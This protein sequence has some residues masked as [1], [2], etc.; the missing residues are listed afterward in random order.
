MENDVAYYFI[1]VTLAILA[2]PGDLGALYRCALPMKR[3][4]LL[5]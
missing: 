5:F 4:E 1:E 3:Y 2:V